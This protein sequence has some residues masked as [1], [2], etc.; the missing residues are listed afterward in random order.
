MSITESQKILRA[1]MFDCF[2]NAGSSLDEF[3]EV[4]IPHEGETT[5]LSIVAQNIAIL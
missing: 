5:M 4:E 2:S 3:L 1:G